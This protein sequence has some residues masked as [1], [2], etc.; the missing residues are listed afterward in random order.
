MFPYIVAVT[1]DKV[2]TFL[3]EVLQTHIQENQS[4]SDTLRDIIRS[5]DFISKHFYQDIG[6]EGGEGVFAREDIREE[7]LKCSGM[8]IFTTLLPKEKVEQKLDNLFKRYYQKFKG[9]LLLKYVCFEQQISSDEDKLE[10]IRQSKQRLKRGDC[11]N[12]II[13][14]NRNI[15]FQ[16]SDT[17]P[18]VPSSVRK[19]SVDNDSVIVSNIN[20]LFT[21]GKDDNSN[22]FRI[23][24]IKADLDGMGDLFEGITDFKLYSRISQLLSRIISLEYLHNC[25]KQKSDWKLYPLYIAG[26]DIFFAVPVAHLKKGIQICKQI[27]NEVNTGIQN[28]NIEDNISPISMSIGVD[29][30]F[31]REPI[32]Y[33]YERVQRQLEIAKAA[34]PIEIKDKSAP[35][36]C[37]KL[38]LNNF[39]F[40]DSFDLQNDRNKPNWNL[41]IHHIKLLRGAMQSGFA[42]QHFFYGLLNKI[43]DPVICASLVKYSNAVLYHLLPHG[44]SRRGKAQRED[45]LLLLE[46]LMNQLYIIERKGRKEEKV[47]SFEPEQRKRLESYVRLM[48]L[49]SDL[50][51]SL[52]EPTDVSRNFNKHK[53]GVRTNLFN[54]PMKYIYENGL[55]E[56]IIQERNVSC[57]HV[58]DFRHQFVR[59]EEYKH[60]KSE[61]KKIQ[62]YRTI[63]LSSSMLHRIKSLGQKDKINVEKTA[64]MI[65]AHNQFTQEEIRELEKSCASEGKAPPRLF[66]D[67]NEFKRLASQPALWNTDYIDSLLI[68]YQLKDLAI[69]YKVMYPKGKNY[70]QG[71]SRKRGASK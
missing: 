58:E 52:S 38:S 48:L 64:E 70:A 46:A 31:N 3:Y 35:S 43:T 53:G 13:K 59:T 50:R 67:Q 65:Q 8:C 63:H 12:F 23:A 19:P 30:T 34:R 17:V 55:K 32:R 56:N 26:D 47:L 44:V 62:V 15:L 45:E 39:V 4:N 29:F 24:V 5:S 68:F 42:A 11:L 57:K 16:F 25:A 33:Y 14:R 6:L 9:Q 51:F 49:F 66:F 10:A 71:K 22:H 21:E 41:F 20:K 37:I 54:K 2:Q 18:T 36:S 69:Q 1:I 27:L 60:P 7:L 40:Y 61:R 28:L